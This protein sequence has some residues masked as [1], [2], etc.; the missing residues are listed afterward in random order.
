MKATYHISNAPTYPL[1]KGQNKIANDEPI[2]FINRAY[3]MQFA[4]NEYSELL[5]N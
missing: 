5:K 2:S 3:G 4:T 1:I